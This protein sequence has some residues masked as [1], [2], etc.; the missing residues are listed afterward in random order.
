M[1]KLLNFFNIFNNKF[2]IKGNYEENAYF[3]LS[4][5]V[6][7]LPKLNINLAIKVSSLSALIVI[8]TKNRKM[9]YILWLTTFFRKIILIIIRLLYICILI[10]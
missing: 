3:K 1:I 5:M 4:K 10:N 8:I 7:Y 9:D 2:K 6:I